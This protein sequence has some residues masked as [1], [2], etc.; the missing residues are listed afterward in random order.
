MEDKDMEESVEEKDVC[1]LN[2]GRVQEYW[3]AALVLQRVR[4]K[5]RL[6][7]DQGVPNVFMIEHM[8]VKSG[9]IWGIVKHLQEL[10]SA[11]MEHELR[12]EGEVLLQTERGRVI[13]PVIGKSGAETDEHA[14]DPPEH[15]RPVVDLGLEHGNARHQNRGRLLV[16]RLGDCGISSW[17][18]QVP[19]DC[20]DSEMELARRVLVVREELHQGTLRPLLHRRGAPLVCDLEVNR[21]TRGRVN[22]THLPCACVANAAFGLADVA[23]FF[24]QGDGMSNKARHLELLRG[25]NLQRSVESHK[26]VIVVIFIKDPNKGLFELGGSK[27]VRQD[28]MPAGIVGEIFH[29]QQANLVKTP[30]KN[31]HDV[32]IMSGTFRQAIVKLS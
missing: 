9:F 12:V 26:Q 1:G 8:S 10:A 5:S 7:H 22:A 29:L 14:V 32:A 28:H 2:R 11:Q 19:R 4:F 18:T 3:L 17:P 31:V 6:N 13:L 27:A 21:I 30:G 15:V 25:Q 24:V 16:K 23:G 20:C